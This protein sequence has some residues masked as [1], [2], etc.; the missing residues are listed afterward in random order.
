MVF[1]PLTE[2]HEEI[3]KCV[4]DSA[5]QV[6]N[7]LGPGLLERVY[8]ACLADE[9]RNSGYKVKRQSN[10][11]IV[12][13]GKVFDEGFR[14]DLNIE[15]L[16]IVEVKAVDQINEVWKAQ[17]ISHLKLTDTRLGYLINFNVP[18]IKD[19]IKRFRV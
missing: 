17:I 3:G 10:V 5:F 7:E 19:G 4:V 11:P 8:E 16:V 13:K 15:N 2:K 18:L 1:L 14:L 6:H 12:Y 9:I